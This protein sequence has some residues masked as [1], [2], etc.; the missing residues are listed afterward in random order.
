MA[1]IMPFEATGITFIDS[2][3]SKADKVTPYEVILNLKGLDEETKANNI[4][5]L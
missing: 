4:L 1:N 5:Y 2:P 3:I